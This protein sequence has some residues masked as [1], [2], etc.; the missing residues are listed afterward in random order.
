MS[1]LPFWDDVGSLDLEP[2]STDDDLSGTPYSLQSNSIE[3]K[4]RLAEEVI[5][6]IE[7][8]KKHKI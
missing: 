4:N 3:N 6:K 2:E 1:G 7:L 5:K 8:R